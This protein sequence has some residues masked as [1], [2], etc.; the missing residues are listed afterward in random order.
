MGEECEGIVEFYENIIKN[1][2]TSEIN[3]IRKSYESGQTNPKKIIET[4]LDII[5][6]DSTNSIVQHS[7]E[8]MKKFAKIHLDQR[9]ISKT[10][11]MLEGMPFVVK[12]NVGVK[13]S[14]AEFSRIQ[15][16]NVKTYVFSRS[17]FS[18]YDSGTWN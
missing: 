1:S 18:N 9:L 16:L 14:A 4:I 5:K 8:E 13:G 15:V 17:K 2:E 12:E 7:P 10:A 11:R 6:T 3:R